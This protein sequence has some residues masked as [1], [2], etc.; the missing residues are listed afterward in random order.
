MQDGAR[1]SRHAGL[2]ASHVEFRRQRVTELSLARRRYARSVAV[3]V[4]V[5]VCVCLTLGDVKYVVRWRMQLHS[6]V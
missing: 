3:H 6:A 5:C 1:E 4:C 2:S